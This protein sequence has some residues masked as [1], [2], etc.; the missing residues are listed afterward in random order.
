MGDENA[1]VGDNVSMIR[2]TNGVG[3]FHLD[4][5]NASIG[6]NGIRME[7]KD[8]NFHHYGNKLDAR[9]IVMDSKKIQLSVLNQNLTSYLT[10]NNLCLN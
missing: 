9:I 3:L 2:G 7:F 5:V 10:N 4:E 8:G 1:K 6:P